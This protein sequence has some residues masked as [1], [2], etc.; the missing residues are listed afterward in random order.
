MGE[1]ATAGI[2]GDFLSNTPPK[3]SPPTFALEDVA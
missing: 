3:V 1:P 2:V